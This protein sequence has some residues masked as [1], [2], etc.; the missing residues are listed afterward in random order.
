[1]WDLGCQAPGSTRQGR[2]EIQVLDHRHGWKEH[3]V[4]GAKTHGLSDLCQI[5]GDLE[6]KDRNASYATKSHEVTGVIRCHQ[7]SKRSR[8]NT[9]SMRQPLVGAVRPQMADIV[10]DLPRDTAPGACAWKCMG[11]CGDLL[12]CAPAVQRFRPGTWCQECGGCHG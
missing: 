12:H 3:S 10:V 6:V 1:M 9:A 2:K 8:E 5:F 7:V 4:L 11:R